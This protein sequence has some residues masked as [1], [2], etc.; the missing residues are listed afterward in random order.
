MAFAK[1]FSADTKEAVTLRKAHA[2]IKKRA[3]LEVAACD[4][5]ANIV[6]RRYTRR[7]STGSTGGDTSLTAEFAL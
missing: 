4:H 1:L 2:V 7:W 5:A 6:R 3:A